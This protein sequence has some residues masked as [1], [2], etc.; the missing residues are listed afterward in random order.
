LQNFKIVIEYDGTAYQGWQRQNEGT[1]IQGTIEAALETMIK[2]PVTVLGSGRTDAGVHALNQVANFRADTKLTP[3]IF[4]R[5]LNSL[6]PPDI[7]IKDCAVVDDAF[8]ARYSA[9]SKVY[10]YRILNRSTP[11]AL[12]RQ[13]AWHIKKPLDLN[14]MSKAIAC[15]KGQHDFSAFEATGS[16]RSDAV[17]TVIDA[18]LAEK[19][20]DGYV[21]L[22]IEANG[23]LRHMV[24]NVVGTMVDVGLG[25]LS[26]EGFEDILMAKDRKK[27]GITAPAHGLVLKEVRY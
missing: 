26:P 7:V 19:D 3:E 8:H 25:K 14:A 2:K 1:T 18:N 13:Y 12:F 20:A 22:S 23:F 24:R 4:K 16:P 6:L 11:A 27:A 15:L 10:Q 21:V 9:W 5:G 17:R